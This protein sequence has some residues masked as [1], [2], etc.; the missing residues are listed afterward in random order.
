MNKMTRMVFLVIIA[1]IGIIAMAFSINQTQKK[2]EKWIIPDKYVQMKNPYKDDASL[3]MVG[4]R[5]YNRHCRSCH[6]K[7][8]LGDGVMAKNLKTFPGDFSSAEI[9]QYTDGEIYYISIIG[10][11][12]M[13]NY[14]KLIPSEEDR[15]AVVNHIRT[16]KK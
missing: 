6:G 1:G 3:N 14:E 5:N 2:G 8:G 9:Q 7:E 10:R 15:W 13:P 11:D 16:M 4:L 12:E